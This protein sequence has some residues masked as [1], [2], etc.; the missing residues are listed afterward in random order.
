MEVIEYGTHDGRAVF[1]GFFH[2][3][4]YVIPEI[5]PDEAHIGDTAYFEKLKN[6]VNKGRP[7]YKQIFKVK[8]REE[9]FIK[10]A[11]MKIVRY[12][13]IPGAQAPATAPEE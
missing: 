6:K 4:S 2:S 5:F 3:V 10:N 11:S 13:N 12:K 1:A 8:L 9:E 7:M